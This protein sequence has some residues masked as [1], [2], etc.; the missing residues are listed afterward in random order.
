MERAHALEAIDDRRRTSIYEMLSK[1]GWLAAEPLGETT[2]LEE[3]QLLGRVIEALGERGYSDDAV[4]AI[5]GFSGVVSASR[6]RQM[7]Q[8]SSR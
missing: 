4:A 3:P 7:A 5:G 1:R 6:V 2:A 8:S